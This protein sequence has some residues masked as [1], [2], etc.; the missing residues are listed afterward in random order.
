MLFGMGAVC[1]FLSLLVVSITV[2]SKLIVKYFS[3]D[4]PEQTYAPPTATVNPG[5]VEPRVLAVIQDAIY[6][7]RA[8]NQP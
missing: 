2:M 8:R 4:E 5:V 1:V 3:L 7:H 6:Q